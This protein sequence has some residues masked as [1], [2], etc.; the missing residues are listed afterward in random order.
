MNRESVEATREEYSV[1]SA[2]RD[3]AAIKLQRFRALP[4]GEFEQK[5]SAFLARRGFNFETTR[6]T[7]Q[8]AWQAI[9]AGE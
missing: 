8:R 1:E 2:A 6:R 5:L 3:A 7:V 9:Q 4:Q